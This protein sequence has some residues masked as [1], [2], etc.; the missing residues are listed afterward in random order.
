MVAALVAGSSLWAQEPCLSHTASERWMQAHGIVTDLAHAATVLE[1]EAGAWRDGVHKI[2]VVVHVVWNTNEEN[3]S[4]TTINNIMVQINADYQAL[5]SDYNNVRAAFLNSRGNPQ[6]EFCL[7]SF[8]PSGEPT[9]GIIR[10]QTSKSWFNPETEMDDMK[11]L[12]NGSPTWNTSKYLNIWICDISSGAT[13]G[14]VTAGYTYLPQT[15]VVG[16]ASDGVVL[17]YTY[18]T[19][20]RTATHEIGHYLGLLHPWGNDNGNCDPGDGIS[21]TPPTDSPTFSCSNSNLMK[22]GALTQFENFMDY[23]TCP[24]MFTNGQASVMSGILTGMRSSLLI[25]TGCGENEIEAC[26]P[27]AEVG[28]ADGEFIN[29]VVLGQ[30]NNTNTGSGTG[31]AYNNYTNLSTTLARATSYTLEVTS[32][33]SPE[34]WIAAWIDFNGNNEFSAD[35]KIGEVE[36][37]GAFQTRSFPFTVPGD[38]ELGQT[39]MRVRLVF[40]DEGDPDETDPCHNYKWGETE[41]YGINITAESFIG[42]TALPAPTIQHLA[43]QVVVSWPGPDAPREAMLLDA[44]GRVVRMMQAH[45]QKLD[46]RTSDLAPGVYQLLL[47]MNGKRMVARFATGLH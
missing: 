16:T 43:D 2:P 3:V 30:I 46:I 8:D 38:A 25:S 21:D 6:I 1:Q 7:A 45:G 20:G 22:C 11:F 41:D 42:T 10:K 47:S 33:E 13:G 36:S 4:N 14:F 39:L 37:G 15:G 17:D 29:G 24:R 31:P 5:N 9:T 12:P 44:M 27:T 28:P 32:G 40:Q 34:G 26:I 18:G 35:E 23:S 19:S